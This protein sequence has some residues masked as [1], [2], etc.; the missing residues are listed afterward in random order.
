MPEN[1]SE[2]EELDVE[3]MLGLGE[4]CWDSCSG[5]SDSGIE[6]RLELEELGPT[7]GWV[8]G[9]EPEVEADRAA[10]TAAAADRLGSVAYF[11]S[12]M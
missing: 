5:S 2:E 4:L 12:R 1:E 7:S 8:E 9:P 3:D 10:A 6:S 11:V